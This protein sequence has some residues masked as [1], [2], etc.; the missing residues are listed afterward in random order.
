VKDYTEV[1]ELL[2]TP[3]NGGMKVVQTTAGLCPPPSGRT[4]CCRPENFQ[5]RWPGW[6]DHGV[7][8][9]GVGGA[10]L[11]QAGDCCALPR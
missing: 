8:A 1:E 4:A 7:Q 11:K 6:L 9:L 2:L 3:E 5:L 10:R